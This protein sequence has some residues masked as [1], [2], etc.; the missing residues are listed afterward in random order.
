MTSGRTGSR[1]DTIDRLRGVLIVVMA[2]DHASYFVRKVHVFESWGLPLPQDDSAAA[3]LT[4]FVTH[5]SAP[6]FFWLMGASVVFAAASRRRE[7]WSEGR[8][9]RFLATR[10]LLLIALQLLIENPA[11]LLGTVGSGDITAPPPGGGREVRLHFGVLYSLGAAMILCAG[12]LW[13]PPIL[14][15]AIAAAAILISQ[16][17][18]PGPEDVSTLHPPWL[19]LLVIPGHTNIWQ[20]FYPVI[21]WFGMAAFGMVFARAVQRSPERAL[22]RAWLGGLVCLAGFV[23]VRVA[24]GFGNIHA[25]DGPGWI[26]FLNLTKYPPSLAFV[27]LMLGLN[28]VLLSVLHA[29]GDRL[30]GRDSPVFVFGQSALAFYLLHLYVYALMGL[31]FLRGASLTVMYCGWLAGLLVLYPVCRRYRAF[32]QRKSPDSVWRLF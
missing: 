19:R 6:G 4:R 13:A 30:G 11:W 14:V 10:G 2:I 24:G 7:G 20:V 15:G 12:L 16:A 18:V 3:F 5:V 22:R 28:L 8:V 21:P 1:F 31:P 32:K 23:P 29:A 9:M 25:F 17:V 26:E 27:L